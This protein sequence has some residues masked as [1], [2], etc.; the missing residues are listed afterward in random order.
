MQNKQT[1]SGGRRQSL[2]NELQLLNA[3]GARENWLVE[4]HFAENAAETPHV[5]ALGVAKSTQKVPA[6]MRTK[7]QQN[8]N[9]LMLWKHR[10]LL[11]QSCCVCC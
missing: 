8:Y 3:A 4:Q 10:H 7:P 1:I 11:L 2:R 6:H 5:Y 9:I